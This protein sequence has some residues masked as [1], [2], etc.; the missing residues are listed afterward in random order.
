[1]VQFAIGPYLR[2]SV[3]KEAAHYRAASGSDRIGHSTCDH[4]F[5][6][7]KNSKRRV[8]AWIRD[9]FKIPGNGLRI[10]VLHP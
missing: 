2:E 8:S 5:A 3:A 1:M 6:G 10:I 9:I 4:I 7:R